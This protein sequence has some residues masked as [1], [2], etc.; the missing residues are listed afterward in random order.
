MSDPRSWVLT[1]DDQFS[2][3]A[4]L[5]GDSSFMPR[6]LQRA[7]VEGSH[8]LIG[9]SPGD[10]T[11]RLLLTALFERYN[12]LRRFTSYNIV[13]VDPL[14]LPS[15]EGVP[16]LIERSLAKAAFQIFWGTPRDFFEELATRWEVTKR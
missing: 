12:S 7:L 14:R 2:C 5:A 4:V 13:V 8:L 11:F 1:E 15:I 6:E 16:R 9:F 10:W 3:L